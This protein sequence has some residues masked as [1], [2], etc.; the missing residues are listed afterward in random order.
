MPFVEGKA[1]LVFENGRNEVLNVRGIDSVRDPFI[2]NLLQEQGGAEC[3]LAVGGNRPG[4]LVS[5]TLITRYRLS[6]GDESATWSTTG[7]SRSLTQSTSP[8]PSRLT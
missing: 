5:E 2:V 6:E 4:A 7:T 8:R 1:M 3:S